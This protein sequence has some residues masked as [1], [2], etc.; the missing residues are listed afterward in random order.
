METGR[1]GVRNGTKEVGTRTERMG[2]GGG[3]RNCDKRSG[4]WEREDGNWN[5]RS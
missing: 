3:N 2:M 5:R 4:N 1:E